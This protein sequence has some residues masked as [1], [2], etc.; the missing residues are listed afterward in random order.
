MYTRQ[1]SVWPEGG[2]CDAPKALTS[3]AKS[4]EASSSSE[5]DSPVPPSETR[6][7]HLCPLSS[8]RQAP[9]VF[10]SSRTAARALLENH[11]SA[12]VVEE[13]GCALDSY[14]NA[15]CFWRARGLV[16]FVFEV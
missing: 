10:V 3:I 8:H 14:T 5:D 6:I 1:S 2:R 9:T 11:C 13:Q 12:R 16:T 4:A 7:P 15:G